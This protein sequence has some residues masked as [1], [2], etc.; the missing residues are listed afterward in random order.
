MSEKKWFIGIDF[1]TS[2]THVVAYNKDEGKFYTS[3]EFYTKSTC[4]DIIDN[5]FN[6][7]TV[8]TAYAMDGE[9]M[10]T[11]YIGRQASKRP[12]LRLFKNMKNVARKLVPE[13][14]KFNQ[15]TKYIEYPFPFEECGMDSEIQFGSNDFP[16]I[17]SVRNLLIRFF[18]GILLIDDT[19]YEINKDTIQ[20]IVIGQPVINKIYETQVTYEETLKNILLKSIEATTNEVLIEVKTEP[21]LAGATY[22]LSENDDNE[23]ILVIDIGGGT[24]DFCILRKENGRLDVSSIGTG[25]NIA[26]NEIDQIFFDLLPDELIKSKEMC[27]QVKEEMFLAERIDPNQ[28]GE[29]RSPQ[30]EINKMRSVYYDGMKNHTFCYDSNSVNNERNYSILSTG[31]IFLN[32]KQFQTKNNIKDVF[33]KIAS[34]LKESLESYSQRQDIDTIFFVGGTSIIYPLREKLTC[35][36][37]EVSSKKIKVVDMFGENTRKLKIDDMDDIPITCY[38]AV[39]IGGCIKA[40]EE[41]GAKLQFK[42]RV[43][44][45]RRYETNFTQAT[46]LSTKKLILI[47]QDSNPFYYIHCEKATVENWRYRTLFYG[48][49]FQEIEFKISNSNFIHT[50]KISKDILFQTKYNLLFVFFI[51]ISFVTYKIYDCEKSFSEID[52]IN[53]RDIMKYSKLLVDETI[54]D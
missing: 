42:P 16:L 38:N 14:G 18:K 3:G 10:P 20:K 7:A 52:K 8:I 28:I 40:M 12:I 5:N 25:C 45:K 21:E 46:E 33:E 2:N 11:Y 19:N 26:G 22:L 23:T 51:N 13:N 47:S 50:C 37:Q 43:F 53:I 35:I 15:T 30:T 24:T 1:G 32:G 39:A 9:T 54:L 4:R 6:A 27:K 49:D 41:M 36:V 17:V 48:E 34:S 31:E 29:T 44:Y